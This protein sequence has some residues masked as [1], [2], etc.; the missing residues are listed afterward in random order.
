VKVLVTG[1]TGLIGSALCDALLKRGDDVVGLTRD[2]S[3]ARL[4][5]PGV[6]WHSWQPMLERP[7]AKAFE[8]IDG[9]VNLVGEKINQRWT[10]GAK[11][12]IMA[13][14]RTATHNLV[15]TIAGLER[16]PRVFVSQS[17]V[18]YYGDRGHDLVDE[19]TGPGSRWTP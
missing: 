17:A 12:R 6:E 4:R 18:G 9:V 14:R 13:S 11:R 3:K 15:G 16:R 5:T 10:E 7:S 2:P 19:S 8:G 1:A